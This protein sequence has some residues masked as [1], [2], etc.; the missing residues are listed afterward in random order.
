MLG[1]QDEPEVEGFEWLLSIDA[2]DKCKAV[3]LKDDE[4][5]KVAKG[6]PFTVVPTAHPDYATIYAPPL[7]P[8]CQ[9]TITPVVD[10]G[11]KTSVVSLKIPTPAA[12]LVAASEG[13]PPMQYLDMAIRLDGDIQEFEGYA[14]KYYALDTYGTIV[15]PGAFDASLPG[16][17]QRN[18]IGNI[19]HDHSK[20]IG[21]FYAATSD[22]VGLYVKGRFSDVSWS[23]DVRTLIKDEVIQGLSVGMKIQ[24]SRQAS[25]AEV[26][27]IWAK[28]NYT[29]DEHELARLNEKKGAVLI[30]KARLREVSPT[31]MPSNEKSEILSYKSDDAGFLT[32]LKDLF[33]GHYQHAEPATQP[34]PEPAPVDPGAALAA[35]LRLKAKLVK[36]A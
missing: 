17:L 15:M 31:A 18:I 22:S 32:K 12:L 8:N 28:A 10:V 36:G 23:R 30:T 13:S 33:F 7:H 21:K 27:R 14:S 26:K 29:P 9:C 34:P 2:C 4:P 24:E 3:G 35:K 16:F 19:D 1:T 5:V 6:Q 25:M 11:L 20:P